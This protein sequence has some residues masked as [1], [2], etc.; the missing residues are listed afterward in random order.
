MRSGS[1]KR[2]KSA[3]ETRLDS[4]SVEVLEALE[5][6]GIDEITILLN[7]IYDTGQIPPD[8]S[9]SIF[10]SLTKKPASVN[11]MERPVL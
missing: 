1:N 3:K 6:Y 5:G 4:I 9:K 2:M 8:I 11:R 7:E 10:I